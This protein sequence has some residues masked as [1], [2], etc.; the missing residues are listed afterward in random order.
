MMLATAVNV[1][2]NRRSR[3]R[4]ATAAWRLGRGKRLRARGAL[5]TWSASSSTFTVRSEDATLCHYPDAEYPGLA[6]Q[7]WRASLL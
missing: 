3:G 6:P 1:L 5:D 4:D 2:S 7:Y